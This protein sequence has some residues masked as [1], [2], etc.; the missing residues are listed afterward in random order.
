MISNKSREKKLTLPV[1][2]FNV[3]N[4]NGVVLNVVADYH[5]KA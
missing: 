3:Q 2:K 4:I 1:E 5:E